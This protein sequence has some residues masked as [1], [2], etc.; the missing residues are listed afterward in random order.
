MGDVPNRFALVLEGALE[1]RWH[2]GLGWS[3]AAYVRHVADNLEA[4]AYRLDAARLDG[5]TRAAGYDADALAGVRDY[6]HATVAASL[7]ALRRI[8]PGWQ[9]AV[10]AGLADGVVLE[11]AARGPQ[12]A[13]DVARNNLHDALHHVHD[14]RRIVEYS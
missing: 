7:Q 12:R 13:Q 1:A 3:S 5:E 11:H 10:S 9:A 8:V 2:P 6:A 14:V 4:W